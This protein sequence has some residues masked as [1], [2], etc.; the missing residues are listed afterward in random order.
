MQQLD[1]LDIFDCITLFHTSVHMV[2]LLLPHNVY[3]FMPT[4]HEFNITSLTEVAI[5][6]SAPALNKLSTTP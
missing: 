3:G 1:D 4:R 5:F 6:T 2:C